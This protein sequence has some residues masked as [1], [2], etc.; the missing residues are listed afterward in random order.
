MNEANDLFNGM[1]EYFREMGL[2]TMVYW[3]TTQEK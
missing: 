3:K 2:F 1:G